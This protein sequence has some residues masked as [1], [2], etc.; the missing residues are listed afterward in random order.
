M[1]QAARNQVRAIAPELLF[2]HLGPSGFRALSCLIRRSFS[3]VSGIAQ[4]Q[5]QLKPSRTY[6]PA[7]GR[8]LSAVVGM[9]GDICRVVAPPGQR[10]LEE[11]W[12][13]RSWKTIAPGWSWRQRKTPPGERGFLTRRPKGQGDARRPSTRLS[14]GLVAARRARV[15]ACFDEGF[16]C[17]SACLNGKWSLGWRQGER[18]IFVRD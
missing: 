12:R 2:D 9:R 1:G 8:G 15:Q 10:R 7:A 11:A 5:P 3:G 18:P 14:T 13:A 17:A 4:L 6:L 16:H